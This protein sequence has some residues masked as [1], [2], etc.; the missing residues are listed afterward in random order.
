MEGMLLYSLNH[1]RNADHDIRWICYMGKVD[2]MEGTVNT[3]IILLVFNNEIN[4]ILVFFYLL[5]MIKVYMFNG[6]SLLFRDLCKLPCNNI[7]DGS[8]LW[9]YFTILSNWFHIVH[10]TNDIVITRQ[11]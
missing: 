7:N 3:N 10:F 2:K 11:E 8:L 9:Q 4:W 1:G 5:Q 6:C